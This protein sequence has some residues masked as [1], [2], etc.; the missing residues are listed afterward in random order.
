MTDDEL[1]SMLEA[2]KAPEILPGQESR[3]LDAYRRRSAAS[4]WRWLWSGSIRV[5]VPA[6]AAALILFF[7]LT[8][9]SFRPKPA[10]VPTGIQAETEFQA[11][12]ALRPVVVRAN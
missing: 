2:W 4:F 12:R 1:K 10:A 3:M 7:V 9:Y 6:A 8:V 5:P 11:V